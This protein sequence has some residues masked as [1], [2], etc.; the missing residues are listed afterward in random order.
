[1][2]CGDSSFDDELLAATL[3]GEPNDGDEVP[4][5]WEPDDV[6]NS[7]DA[8]GPVARDLPH[9]E[10]LIQQVRSATLT[11]SVL[12]QIIECKEQSKQRLPY[13]LIHEHNVKVDLAGCSYRD[14][15]LYVRD[16][17]FVPFDNELRAR[18]VQVHHDSL[19]GGHGGRQATYERLSR[20]YFWPL[21]TATVAQ[22]CRNCL[23][24]QRSKPNKE[25]K[26][27]LLNPFP[28]PDTYWNSI[29]ADFR[30]F[31]YVCWAVAVLAV[32]WFPGKLIAAFLACQPLSFNWDSS[33]PGGHCGNVS[34]AYI[35]MHPSNVFIDVTIALL[36]APILWGLQMKASKRVAIIFMF[37]LGAL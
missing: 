4:A 22:Y 27:G 18:I 13:K 6:A 34:V 1:M 24:C 32:L 20:H 26:H 36:P 37:S 19:P 7:S 3:D 12:Q 21:A 33:V 11:D 14:G 31:T 35:T 5:D 30:R 23:T 10:S 8:W 16:K 28:V 15:L 9:A 25:G 2:A 17:I 29:S